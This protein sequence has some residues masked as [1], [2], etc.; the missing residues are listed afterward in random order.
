MK[1]AGAPVYTCTELVQQTRESTA[2]ELAP[3]LL[4]GIREADTRRTIVAARIHMLKRPVRLVAR[5]DSA[6]LS[7]SGF[8]LAAH[9]RFGLQPV[10]H[11]MSVQPAALFIQIVSAAADS[12]IVFRGLQFA[13]SGSWVGGRTATHEYLLGAKMTLSCRRIKPR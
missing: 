9:F 12:F 1:A 5:L 13:F 6:A 7:R 10:I 2:G 11:I 8:G 4:M 3:M